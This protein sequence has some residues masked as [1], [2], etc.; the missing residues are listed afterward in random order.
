MEQ[1]LSCNWRIK[2]GVLRICR[3]SATSALSHN[4]EIT[5]TRKPSLVASQA[6]IVGVFVFSSFALA[7]HSSPDLDPKLAQYVKLASELTSRAR[8]NVYFT[9][10]QDIF[11]GV[12]FNFVNVGLGNLTFLRR[13]L[14]ASGRIPI[15]FA[16]VYDSSASGSADFGPGWRLSATETI[17]IEDHTA[18]LSSE[19][20]YTIEFTNA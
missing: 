2:S 12:Q 19:S 14:V 8:A 17:S 15:V 18:K 11:R 20:G 3:L 5:M 6:I 1:L 4:L 10:P 16:R 13:D 7:Q 9:N